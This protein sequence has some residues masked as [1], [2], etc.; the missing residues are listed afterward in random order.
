[1]ADEI[2]FVPEEDEIEFTPEDGE[3]VGGGYRAPAMPPDLPTGK[4]K[5]LIEKIQEY[6]QEDIPKLAGYAAEQVPVVGQIAKKGVEKLAGIFG[7]DPKFDER[8]KY[9]ESKYPTETTVAKMLSPFALGSLGAPG[10]GISGATGLMARVGGQAGI[11]AADA[12]LRG[13]DPIQG[14][15]AAGGAQ[16]ALEVVPYIGKIK[17]G[18]RS[19]AIDKAVDTMTKDAPDF[20]VWRK[21]QGKD[22]D[23]IGEEALSR[24]LLGWSPSGTLKKAQD[25]LETIGQKMNDNAKKVSGSVVVSANKIAD[26]IENLISETKNTDA[27]NSWLQ[28]QADFFRKKRM[29]SFAKAQEAKS[30]RY[31][32][33]SRDPENLSASPE[34][35]RSVNRIIGDEMEN[36]SKTLT[37]LGNKESKRAAVEWLKA[38]KDYEAVANVA[39]MS[40]IGSS[41][42]QFK[43]PGVPEIATVAIPTAVGSAYNVGGKAMVPAIAAALAT[44]AGRYVKDPAQAK[45]FY[46]MYK[47]LNK[48]PKVAQKYTKLLTESANKGPAA[49]S[50]AHAFLMNNEPEYKISFESE[51]P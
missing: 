17:G 47:A 1:M 42:T 14:A 45:V 16:S 6:P 21:M 11:S 18:L 2:D 36:I 9:L 10:S 5:G 13:N 23:K 30:G 39:S 28:K 34:A 7:Q 29:I 50:V 41:K 46:G 12:A 26:K 38:K 20:Q 19:R 44:Y 31:K 4:H 33:K 43:A 3:V 27:V 51:E 24:K 49:L 32:W 22:K 37:D 8:S 48:T 15:I 40:K 35:I 25:Q